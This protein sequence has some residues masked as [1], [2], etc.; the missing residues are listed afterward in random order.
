MHHLPL[1]GLIGG[2]VGWPVGKAGAVR[3]AG[4]SEV[5]PV[6]ADQRR[7][8]AVF[9]TPY[10][11]GTGIESAEDIFDVVGVEGPEEGGMVDVAGRAQVETVA[12]DR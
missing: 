5:G 9:R 4:P 2:V 7:Q 11:A 10:C 6:S 1:I 3:V 8:F 12:E